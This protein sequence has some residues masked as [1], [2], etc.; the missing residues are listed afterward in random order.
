MPS[1]LVL[2]F[3]NHRKLSKLV[4]DIFILKIKECIKNL[5]CYH[6][7]ARK[8]IKEQFIWLQDSLFC[9][10]Y[11]NSKKENASYFKYYVSQH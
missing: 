5:S 9:K 2:K 11:I 10:L 4:R 3:K 7:Y 8:I 1:V 6:V